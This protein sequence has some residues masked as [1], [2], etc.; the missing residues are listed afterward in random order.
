MLRR[1]YYRL[2]KRYR[3]IELNCFTYSNADKLIRENEG[4]PEKD[5]WVI[6]REEDKNYFYGM[7]WLE[8]K[9]RIYQ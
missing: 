3:R 5:Q 6:A 9:E 8:R 4:K 2:F 1:L 7:V